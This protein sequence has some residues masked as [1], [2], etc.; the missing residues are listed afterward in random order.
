MAKDVVIDHYLNLLT[1]EDKIVFC[2]SSYFDTSVVRNG[3]NGVLNWFKTYKSFIS[4]N[5]LFQS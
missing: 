1:N 4:K 3:I 2:F 5:F